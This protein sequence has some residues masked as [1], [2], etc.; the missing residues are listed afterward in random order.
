[1]AE[2]DEEAKLLPNLNAVEEAEHRAFKRGQQAAELKGQLETHFKDDDRRFGEI[3]TEQSQTTQTLKTV[4][5]KVDNLGQKVDT[6]AAITAARAEDAR[7][8]AD[9]AI[10]GRQFFLGLAGLA[11][12]VVAAILT[13]LAASGHL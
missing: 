13:A 5:V 6:A 3:K 2:R 8:A 10:S 1:M 7:K 4:V 9:N 12:T 11:V